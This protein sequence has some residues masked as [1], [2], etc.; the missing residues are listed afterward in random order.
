MSLSKTHR[1]N[2]IIFFNETNN[3]KSRQIKIIL[4]IDFFAST[5][6]KITVGG[7]VNQLIK[8]FWPKLHVMSEHSDLVLEDSLV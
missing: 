1:Q 2:L 8:K 3:I 4:E 5:I 7:F 6:W